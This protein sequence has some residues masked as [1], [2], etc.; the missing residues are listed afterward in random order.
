MK[1]EIRG[2]RELARDLGADFDMSEGFKKAGVLVEGSWKDKAHKVTRKYAGSLGSEV[3]G[4]GFD[5]RAEVGPQPGTGQPRGYTRSQ[6]SHWKKPRAGKNT[7]D[8]QEYAVFEDQGTKYRPGHPAAEPALAENEDRIAEVIAR[9]IEQQL[10]R[11]F[12]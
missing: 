2:V 3:L 12:R 5:I 10:A 9:D 6:T 4:R 8:P 7:G 11:R 1:V